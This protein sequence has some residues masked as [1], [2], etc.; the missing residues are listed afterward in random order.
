MSSN[1]VNR[2]LPSYYELSSDAGDEAVHGSWKTPYVSV[3]A[4]EKMPDAIAK[5]HDPASEPTR[6]GSPS[7]FATGSASM[8]RGNT[9]IGMDAKINRRTASV[10]TDDGRSWSVDFTLPST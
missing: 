1:F 9:V 3:E 2:F 4:V 7:G 10:A 6:P 5:P 8:R